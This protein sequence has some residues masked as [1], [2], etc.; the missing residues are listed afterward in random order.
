MWQERAWGEVDTVLCQTQK[1]TQGWPSK[2]K[3]GIRQRYFEMVA[4]LLH[5]KWEQSSEKQENILVLLSF[6][7]LFCYLKYFCWHRL[8]LSAQGNPFMLLFPL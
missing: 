4:K 3:N 1:A 5:T 8:V 2:A 6:S 7:W